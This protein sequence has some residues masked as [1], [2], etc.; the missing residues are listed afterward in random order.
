MTS[1]HQYDFY[2]Y[3][4]VREALGHALNALGEM[5]HIE[6]PYCFQGRVKN[7]AVYARLRAADLANDE[8]RVVLE[9]SSK[10]FP[11]FFAMA[12]VILVLEV[13][14][15]EGDTLLESTRLVWELVDMG[16]HVGD[17]ARVGFVLKDPEH[18]K[19]ALLRMD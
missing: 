12:D 5:G 4:V 1:T 9:F 13:E 8:T 6:A 10:H 7:P 15:V 18:D 11:N 14:R 19:T 2:L 16:I 17:N 3:D